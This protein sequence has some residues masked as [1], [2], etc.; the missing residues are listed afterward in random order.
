[1]TTMRIN[2]A[3]LPLMITLAVLLA[4]YLAG[5][6]MFHQSNFI[7]LRVISN[8]LHQNAIIAVAAI[9]AT[10]VILSG[11]ID[12]SVGA[13]VAFTTILVAALINAGWH[14]LLA[15]AAAL[16]C[17]TTM[18]LVM[19]SLIHAFR[20]PPFMVTL[21]GMFFA[22]AMAFMVSS[23]SLGIGHSLYVD[24]QSLRLPLSAR[25][26]LSS[27]ALVAVACYVIAIIVAHFTSY[28]R[29][30]Y[31]IGGDET[32]AQLMGVPVA[33]TRIGTYAIAGFCS[34]L[35][36]ILATLYRSSGDPA[37]FIGMELEAIAAVVIG[38]TLI[39]GG[40]GFM[41]GTLAGALI[42]GLIQTMIDFHGNISSWWTK[43]VVG[44]LVL[45][46]IILQS[47]LLRLSTRRLRAV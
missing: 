10:L 41:I 33:R 21:A 12:L 16:A 42:A 13:V 35:A 30:V 5:A 14:P 22:R 19:G 18:G 25:A 27:I 37:A 2:P 31:A 32:S 4:M 7:S 24:I 20:L 34:A 15:W 47:L 44:L 38:G 45:T 1:M 6:A 11:G 26:S 8:L 40:V 28:G 46:F 39:S 43:I 17:G 3:V 23:D 36:G 29:Y 9:G